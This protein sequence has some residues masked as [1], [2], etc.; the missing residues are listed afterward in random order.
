M[1]LII[2]HTTVYTYDT[3]ITYLIQAV[4]MT[5]QPHDG[6]SIRRWSVTTGSGLAM[7]SFVDGF[8][9]TVQTHTVRTEALTTSLCVEGEVE[10]TDTFG[11][12]RNALEPLDPQFYL[13][14]TPQ[15]ASNAAI[16]ALALDVGKVRASDPE[17]LHALMTR[18]RQRIDFRTGETHVH[19]TGAEALR[20]GA[21]VCQ[22]HAHVFIAAARVLGF[23]A[24][25]ISGYLWTGND[26]VSPASHAWA[27][28]YLPS[29]GWV[30]FDIA[31]RLCP[32]D[33]YVRVAVGRDYHDAAPVRGVRRGG[34]DERMSVSVRVSA[35]QVS[36]Q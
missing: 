30:G 27:E 34:Q 18:I 6:L 19:T 17:R 22:D 15:T 12:I 1:R 29:L 28:A 25:Y 4:R 13:S 3:P 11:V 8:G 21:G 24:R 23:P 16:A 26:D 20:E 35:Q 7:P 5:P 14:E 2:R 9:N 31:N 10:T 36:Q 33:A 32:T